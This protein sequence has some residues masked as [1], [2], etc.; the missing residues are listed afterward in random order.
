[1]RARGARAKTAASAQTIPTELS[2][3]DAPP[4]GVATPALMVCCCCASFLRYA[5]DYVS[6]C[7]P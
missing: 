3:A 7:K 5:P 6:A 2:R 1:M 4:D